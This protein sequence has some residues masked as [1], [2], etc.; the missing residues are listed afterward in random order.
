[1]VSLQNNVPV[2]THVRTGEYLREA[3][4]NNAFHGGRKSRLTYLEMQISLD[5]KFGRFT[6]SHHRREQSNRISKRALFY[7]SVLLPSRPVH[8]NQINFPNTYFG[9]Q[10][11]SIHLYKQSV[12][13]WFWSHYGELGFKEEDMFSFS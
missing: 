8:T 9:W 11:L 13:F 5:I 2:N 1:M 10:F 4:G 7:R 12:Q 3:K 6:F